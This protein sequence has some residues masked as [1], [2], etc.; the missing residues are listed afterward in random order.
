MKLHEKKQKDPNWK[1]PSALLELPELYD[2]E[3]RYVKMFFVLSPSRQQGMGIGYIPYSEITN[4][5][6]FHEVDDPE[7]FIEVIQ[8]SDK[9]Y[10]EAT[11]DKLEM[12]RKQ[13]DPPKPPPTPKRRKPTPS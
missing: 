12:K 2:W 7:M 4:Y 5:C 8:K 1:T 11:N 10:V 13:Q 9:A 3:E 6:T